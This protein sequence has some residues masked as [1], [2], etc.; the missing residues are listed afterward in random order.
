MGGWYLSSGGGNG[1]SGAEKRGGAEKSGLPRP[2]STT[3]AA[4]RQLG[5]FSYTWA[6]YWSNM[7]LPPYISSR[8]DVVDHFKRKFY[9]RYIVLICRNNG[10]EEVRGGANVPES[11]I[12]QA[13]RRLLDE[14]QSINVLRFLHAIDRR[15]DLTNG[16]KT[17]K[18]RT[19]IFVGD[20]FPFHTKSLHMATKLGKRYIDLV[21]AYNV[22]ESK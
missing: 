4:D 6:D 15:P 2:T 17:L 3:T 5:V 12:V 16:L 8:S 10:I 21:E 19:L 13:C 18:C 11:D 20:N 7:L 9:Q 22:L 1:R 14:R